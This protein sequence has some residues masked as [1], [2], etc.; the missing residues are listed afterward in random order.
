M[1]MTPRTALYMPG[2]NQRAMEKARGL[3][4]DAI[5]FDLEDA[6]APE[7]K[8]QARAQV[9]AQIA[10]GGYG[11]RQLVVRCNALSTPWGLD[12]LQAV[13]AAPGVA[14][15][16]LPKVESVQQVRAVT[17]ELDACG[18][19]D[20]V[21][22]A[23]IETPAGVAR[24]EQIADCERV[25][26]L[27]MGTTDLCAELRLP[28][29]DQRR[30]LSYALQRCVLAARLAGIMVLD[31]VYLDIGNSAGLQA[32]CEQGRALGFDGKTL[33]H[34]GQIEIANAVFGPSAAAVEHARRLLALWQETTEAG[35]AVAVLD[36]KLIESMHVD[37]ARRVLATAEH[38]ARL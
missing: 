14:T 35:A 30:G 19:S 34:P 2:S 16:C 15:V 18:R 23:M 12:D 10:A 36:G 37:E 11:A 3:P 1:K 8:A 5:V 21:I 25:D 33:I 17:R 26:A 31:G 38:I 22:W 9:V 28:P 13:A 6:V 4:A 20:M 29:D 24:V 7:A 27:L 32:V